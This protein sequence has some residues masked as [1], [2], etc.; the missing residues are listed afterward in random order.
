MLL[1]FNS[2]NLFRRTY[3]GT[4]SRLL[5]QQSRFPHGSNRL[6]SRTGK[7]LGIPLQNGQI[8]WVCIFNR[9]FPFGNL[10]RLRHHDFGACNGSKD[11]ARRNRRIPC[12]NEK[13]QM[14]W[15]ACSSFAFYHHELLLGARRLLHAVPVFEP[16]GTQLRTAEFVWHQP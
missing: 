16:S 13:I 7:Y 9:L 1:L 8:R 15:L 3:N 5:G 11:Q 14:D 6:C 4:Q 10:C 12:D 2:H